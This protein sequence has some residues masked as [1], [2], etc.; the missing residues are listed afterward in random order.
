M[1]TPWAAPCDDGL[2][3]GEEACE[4][5]GDE[6]CEGMRAGEDDEEEDD[7][8]EEAPAA[9]WERARGL[10]SI[11]REDEEKALALGDAEC[12]WAGCDGWRP[13]MRCEWCECECEWCGLWLPAPPPPLPPSIER[14][15]EREFDDDMC[16]NEEDTGTAEAAG[17]IDGATLDD[18]EAAA[19]AAAAAAGGS[20]DARLELA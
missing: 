1:F 19:A 5:R 3:D 8:E 10:W 18:D 20:D 13:L 2:D 14:F 6:V 15:D 17:W 9:F 16:A 4:E 11:G 7:E 12:E